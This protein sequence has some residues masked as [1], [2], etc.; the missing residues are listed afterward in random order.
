MVLGV[1]LVVLGVVL[2]VLGVV[3]V[4]LHWAFIGLRGSDSPEIQGAQPWDHSQWIRLDKSVCQIPF[5]CL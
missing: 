2:V 5:S 1:V 3:L 4:V